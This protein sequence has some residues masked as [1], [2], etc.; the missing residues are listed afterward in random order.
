MT[1]IR[2]GALIV[3]LALLAGGCIG[4]GG[5]EQPQAE[6][7]AQTS[8]EDVSASQA[9]VE[10][11]RLDEVEAK[12]PDIEDAFELS[13]SAADPARLAAFEWTVPEDAI[14]E[15][16]FD[17]FDEDPTTV[18]LKG[19]PRL[20]DEDGEV[21]TWAVFAF[22]L[23]GSEAELLSVGVQTDITL[24]QTGLASSSGEEIEPSA[25]PFVTFL[26][27]DDLSPGDKVGFVLA[28]R[29]EGQQTLNLTLRALDETP[30]DDFPE[31]PEDLEALENATN[32]TIPLNQKAMGTG[33]H[34]ASYG[35]FSF[36][37]NPT[38]WTIQTP[39]LTVEEGLTEERP[40]VASARSTTIESA[41][42]AD[43]GWATINA[44]TFGSVEAG[45]W[46]ATARAHDASIESSGAIVTT[47][48]TST[49]P[50]LGAP[51]FGLAG[52]GAG[53]SGA[54]F[55]IETASVNDILF[56]THL[57]FGE[58]PE[59]LFGVPAED[60]EF[61][62]D[63]IVSAPALAAEPGQLTFLDP[64]GASV[65]TILDVPDDVAEAWEGF[66]SHREG[67]LG[68]GLSQ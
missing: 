39:G 22:A 24:E 6:E 8:A 2:H 57:A 52:G 65:T 63:G 18:I 27:I 16:P 49:S 26:G 7:D 50:V 5:D 14:V 62:W 42:E 25:S 58:E 59:A 33:L 48:A 3:V 44:L 11:A 55:T 46:E 56:F 51:T 1:R 28:A 17:P 54:E 60:I 34:A 35:E 40:P 4:I 47:P 43:G 20:A 12:V 67:S 37:V 41:F 32:R 15:Y 31:P 10:E 13:T 36:L 30:E 64:S 45:Q 21:P 66:S 53:S 61:P 29:G 38:R 68:D 9:N 19:V 23:D